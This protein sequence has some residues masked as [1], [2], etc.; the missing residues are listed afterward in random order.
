M[1][2]TG[3]QYGTSVTALD[4]LNFTAL[5][6]GMDGYLHSTG[7]IQEANR[8]VY[9]DEFDPAT[10]PGVAAA[11]DNINIHSPIVRRL[12]LALNLRCSGLPD[13]VA[14]AVK[15]AV[16][17]IVNSSPNG[18][19]IAISKIVAEAQRVTGVS[20]VSVSSPSYTVVNDVINVPA[21]EKA[22]ILDPSTDISL[23][24]TSN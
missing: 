19:F 21:Y 12:T 23:T 3:A 9:G 14:S 5:S 4:K 6:S 8:V 1:G 20:A 7:L 2:L 11:G 15:G 24:F 18:Q 16:A 22:L 13:D 17:G 10:Y